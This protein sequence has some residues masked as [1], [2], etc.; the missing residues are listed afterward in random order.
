MPSL[1]FV[2]SLLVALAIE[3]ALLL[4]AFALIVQP[5]P[6]NVAPVEKPLEL[7]FDEPKPAVQEP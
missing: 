5:R 2:R 4:C 7:S 3:F 1:S 6:I